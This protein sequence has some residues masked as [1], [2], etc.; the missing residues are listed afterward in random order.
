MEWLSIT[1]DGHCNKCIV[2]ILIQNVLLFSWQAFIENNFHKEI[3]KRSDENIWNNRTPAIVV[4]L[5]KE[6][7]F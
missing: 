1:I 5:F 2:V 4:F 3:T 6:S 7:F